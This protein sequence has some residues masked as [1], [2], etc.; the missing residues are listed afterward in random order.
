MEVDGMDEVGEEGRDRPAP[1]EAEV[2]GVSERDDLDEVEDAKEE[3]EDDA[4]EV[5]ADEV[6]ETLR[7]PS[8][9][10]PIPHR[11]SR[12]FSIFK[13]NNF[14]QDQIQNLN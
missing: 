14:G 13:I 7:W 8:G 9:G 12:S 5:E 11:L 2:S 4:L 10:D 6:D 3:E 1:A